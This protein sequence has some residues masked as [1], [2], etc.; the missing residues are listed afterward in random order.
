M[1][2]GLSVLNS[3][4]PTE[5]LLTN[6]FQIKKFY[7]DFD[8][9]VVDSNSE[10]KDIYDKIDT[11]DAKI[12]F[13]KNLNY[14]YGAWYHALKNYPN[15]KVYMFLQDTLSPKNRI[16]P[17][18]LNEFP[19]NNF[20]SWHYQA[21]LEWGGYIE[22]LRNVYCNTKLDFISKLPGS[23]WIT[24]GGHNS[25]ITSNVIAKEIVFSIET[26]YIEK[27]ISKSKIDSWLSER[28]TGILA[29]HLNL[30]RIDFSNDFDKK[31][32]GRV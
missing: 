29:N 10:K 30:N 8:I 5:D 17:N 25:F 21:G 24:G 13:A 12:D 6:I 2:N 7:P 3:K 9:L 26:P 19:K 28:T 11:D 15:Y 16:I 18:D 22:D 23:T 27:R 20:Y 4:N 1:K 31:H 32:G 14:E